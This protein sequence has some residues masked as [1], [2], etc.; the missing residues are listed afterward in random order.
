MSVVKER[1]TSRLDLRMSEEQRSRIDEAARLSGMSVSQWSMSKLMESAREEIA[2]NNLIVLAPSSFDEFE[3]LL[4]QEVD[5]VFEK[6]RSRATRWE[7]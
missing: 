6:T 3:R 7:R 4:E 5:P 1:K 2:Q